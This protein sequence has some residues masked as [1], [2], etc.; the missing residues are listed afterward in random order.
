MDIE[1]TRKKEKSKIWLHYFVQNAG[2]S[3]QLVD[4]YDGSVWSD[5]SDEFD[6][7]G[8]GTTDAT[9]VGV[10]E[11]N[12]GKQYAWLTST[13]AGQFLFQGEYSSA[14]AG[15][16]PDWSRTYVPESSLV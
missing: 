11:D 3:P 10:G 5:I 7:D 6:L 14:L 4:E 13:E 8:N 1:S 16:S 9:F 15:A 12:S 2:L